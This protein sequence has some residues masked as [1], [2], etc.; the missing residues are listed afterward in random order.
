[1]IDMNNTDM[2]N[3]NM[4]NVDK[5]VTFIEEGKNTFQRIGLELE[6]FVCDKDYRAISYAEISE[7]LE[8]ICQ[9]L[10]GRL[11][12]EQEHIL[13]IVCEGFTVTLEP[14]CQLEI[15]ISPQ[16][17]MEHIRQIYLKFRGVCDRILA[18]KGFHMLEKGV[19]PLVENG[20]LEADAL[21]LIP[22][23]RYHLMDARFASAGGLGRYMM[24]A[25][26]STQVSID[27][28]SEEDALQ[29][30]RV[31]I[32]L[33]PVTALMTENKNGLGRGDKWR[34]HLIRNQIWQDV[35]PVRCGY[36]EHS[37]SENYSFREYAAYVYSNPCILLQRK[38][39]VVDLQGRS[40][41]D[42]YGEQEI[43]AIEHLL[44][45]YF[46]MVRL[47]KYIEYR[48]ADSMPIEAALGYAAL[49]KAIVYDQALL[50]QIDREL[51]FVQSAEDIYQAENSI[52]AR[53]Y[54]AEVYGK[55]VTE[56]MEE[57][58][59]AAL[60]KAGEKEQDYIRRI[61]PLPVL[62]DQYKK[63]VAGEESLH[64]ESAAAIRS[65]LLS[66]TAKYHNRVVRTL[67]LPK[68]F[69][70]KEIRIFD[71]AVNT[72]YGI[73][74]KVIAEFEQS[75]AYRQLFGF[76]EEL[77]ELILRRPKYHCNIPIS[78]IDIFYHEETGDFRFCE[79]NTD[80]TS[81]MNE[82]R[83]LNTAFESSKAYQAFQKSYKLQ[84][85][86]LFDT[87][88]EEAIRLYREYAGD[89][90]ALPSVAI[91]DFMEHATTNEFLIFRDRFEKKGC[92]AC[93]C[94]IRKLT[95]DGTCC[96]TED[97]T[98]ID[99]IYRRAVTSDILAHYREVTD[100]INAVK[101]GGVCLLGDF[102]TQ[103]VHNK[104]LFKLL[105]KPETL[106][107]LSYEEQVFIRAH[108][109]ATISLDELDMPAYAW[110]KNNTCLNKDNWIIKPEDSY[111]SQ[112]VH[113]GV[114][115]ESQDEWN[116]L[117]KEKQGQHYIL[118]QFNDPYRLYN[119][120]LLSEAPKWVDTGNLTGLFVYGGKFSGIYSRIS[121]D[122]MIS[123]QYNEMSLPTVVVS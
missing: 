78:R 64:K 76:P 44:S 77:E 46:P 61:V 90:T 84:K 40:A 82:D 43:D 57:L 27:F 83:E 58:I 22:K 51:S 69:T 79:F 38:G 111:G 33:A 47:K 74:D 66:S 56:W 98:R 59:G 70:E 50:D 48:V 41:A 101:A 118:Q 106:Q 2:S 105:H 99:L 34:P 68:L 119:I 55:P 12:K 16:D 20:E 97:G 103:I 7:C 75:A 91:V 23:E 10:Q 63:L 13:G 108:V 14:G 94:D 92:R 100:F 96:L 120:D 71:R 3:V 110:I 95:W 113:A 36:F 25:T 24:R 21:P 35:D 93:L 107:L 85:F 11:Y 89:E 62:N 81:A 87:W 4:N 112:G 18:R 117:L 65:Y 54:H 39:Q 37:M 60:K 26:A 28:S 104:I 42:Y 1:M 123:T 32:K 102:R 115:L 9:T 52:I 53:G 31:L 45:M 6:H 86:E 122:K 29:K 88:V 80:G 67:Y 5:I 30:M 49:I 15:S 116:R 114:E 72:L 73:F 109:P 17:D 19:F 8:E 121:F